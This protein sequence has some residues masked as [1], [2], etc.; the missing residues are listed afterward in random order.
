MR[1]AIVLA[2]VGAIAGCGTMPSQ[3][4]LPTNLQSAKSPN[5]EDARY[6]VGEGS[7]ADHKTGDTTL[8]IEQTY[9]GMDAQIRAHIEV[10]S[11]EAKQLSKGTDVVSNTQFG[12]VVLGGIGAAADALGASRLG[13]AIAGGAGVWGNRYQLEV[14]SANYHTAAGAMRCILN[15]INQVGKPFWDTYFYDDG[16]GF[17]FG[18][19]FFQQQ[20]ATDLVT[21]AADTLEGLPK[22]VNTA[23]KSV[24]DKLEVA[25]KNI[26]L[27]TPSADDIANALK[28]ARDNESRSQQQTRAVIAGVSANEQTLRHKITAHNAN[29]RNLASDLSKQAVADQQHHTQV[30]LDLGLKKP[31]AGSVDIAAAQRAAAEDPERMKQA[32][33]LPL[34]LEVCVK[35]V[36]S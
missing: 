2:V 33:Q 32:L 18:R 23:I 13:A 21:S 26:K 14:Q 36:G 30:A 8:R 19:V 7:L 34:D 3:V 31:V 10:W 6:G 1:T 5:P 28:K 24:R 12:G 4:K 20:P 16:T 35:G 22:T 11:A 15:E 27:V 17:R 29:M 25:Q 9:N